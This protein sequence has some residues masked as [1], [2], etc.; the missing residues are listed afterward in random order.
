MKSLQ[1]AHTT[2]SDTESQSTAFAHD[3]G[4]NAAQQ[5]QLNSNTLEGNTESAS[6]WAD[7]SWVNMSDSGQV[8]GRSAGLK[9][10]SDTGSGTVTMNAL[11]TTVQC[12]NGL[13]EAH[14]YLMDHQAELAHKS[15]TITIEFKGTVT[16]RAQVIWSYYHPNHRL[17]LKGIGNAVVS[18]FDRKPN[19]K[20]KKKTAV[21]GYFLA[22]RPIIN[23]D[24]ENSPAKANFSM[25]NLTVE[26]YVSGG[27]EISPRKGVLPTSNGALQAMDP[28]MDHYHGGREAFIEGAMFTDN[29]FQKMGTKYLKKGV[30]R[31]DT[32]DPEAYKYAGYGG[33]MARGL[34][35]SVFEGNRFDSLIN[36]DS[37]VRNTT[38]DENGNALK[39]EDS[40]VNWEGLIHGIYLNNQSSNNLVYDNAFSDISGAPV[41][42]TDRSN[43]NIVHKNTSDNA[44]KN[45]FI[46]EHF[47]EAE[48]K[49]SYN[50]TGYRERIK[51]NKA[52][53]IVSRK[54]IIDRIDPKKFKSLPQKYQKIIQNLGLY[55][56]QNKLGKSFNSKD[57]S[58]L[59]REKQVI[60]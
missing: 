7:T 1:S 57:K 59:Y 3:F 31:Y 42:L 56:G 8:Q 25:D 14:S 13:A 54:D 53:D 20:I 17:K 44:G 22:Y 46:L 23:Q 19:G 41:K 27:V 9:N 29:V 33:I 58:E 28:E 45:A 16:Q 12:K 39:Y 15:G 4:S 38:K 34:S 52:G 30:E 47:N 18:G 40:E 51:T 36:R 60:Q 5:A 48:G 43:D 6:A 35:S 10:D 55:F 37:K 32:N 50:S 49:E 2:H 11:G 24:M 26:G 21:P